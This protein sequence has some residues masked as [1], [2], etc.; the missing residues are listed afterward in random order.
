M[1][2][3]LHVH[4]R[5]SEDSINPPWLIMKMLRKR[6]LDGLAVTDHNTARGWKAMQ[7]P[8]KMSGLFLIL[9]EEIKI[10]QNGKKAGEIIGLF[11]NE[12]IRRGDAWEVIDQIRQ[13]DGIVVI[14]HPFDR[15]KGFRNLD[16]F[17]GK[18][19][20][21]EAF[22]SRLPS[23][24]INDTAFRFAERTGTGM[25]GGSDAHAPW[26]V[27]LAHTLAE[28]SDLE[29]FRKAL[30][31]RD[32]HPSGRMEFPVMHMLSIAGLIPKKVEYLL[33]K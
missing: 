7:E 8:A 4:T 22:N 26:E 3:D 13:Q 12:E 2:L 14:A 24:V 18:I 19:D 21:V 20:A 16:S 25:T 6:G 23:S 10:T 33:S 5:Y 1:K 29:G 11:L 31:K 9:G 30:K 15:I 17:I 28:A 27:G 32:T